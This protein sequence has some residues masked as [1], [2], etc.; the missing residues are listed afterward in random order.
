MAVA[1][2]GRVIRGCRGIGGGN[3]VGERHP[4]DHCGVVEV[5]V[6]GWRVHS[7]YQGPSRIPAAGACDHEE[8]SRVG[9]GVEGDLGWEG[10]AFNLAERTPRTGVHPQG[11]GVVTAG[12]IGS[13]GYILGG[14][15]GVP[16]RV[17]E[18]VTERIVTGCGRIDGADAVGKWQRTD[19]RGVVEIIVRGLRESRRHVQQR[20]QQSRYTDNNQPRRP[21]SSHLSLLTLRTSG[22]CPREIADPGDYEQSPWSSCP[23]LSVAGVV[24]CT[25][26]GQSRP[27]LHRSAAPIWNRQTDC[28]GRVVSELALQSPRLSPRRHRAGCRRSLEP[29]SRSPSLA[30]AFAPRASQ[31]GPRHSRR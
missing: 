6:G 24:T 22:R 17:L 10:L 27:M 3:A 16:N 26:A 13:D 11:R 29:Q 9:S 1:I 31:P 25:T 20:Y 28:P 30:A 5:V 8:V 2:A 12:C 4:T 19:H 23:S 21:Q 15:E 7:E 14:G 18:A